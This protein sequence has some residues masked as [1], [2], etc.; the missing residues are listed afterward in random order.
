[1]NDADPSHVKQDNEKQVS[2]GL[3]MTINTMQDS[4]LCHEGAPDFVPELQPQWGRVEEGTPKAGLTRS[5]W[6]AQH[7]QAGRQFAVAAIR[8]S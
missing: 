2:L 3:G 6:G 4:V 7:P 5:A 1:M 8:T